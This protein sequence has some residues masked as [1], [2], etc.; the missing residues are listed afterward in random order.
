MKGNPYEANVSKFLFQLF[1]ATREK[2]GNVKG[3]FVFF[4]S[5]FWD[6]TFNK[7]KWNPEKI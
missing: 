6:L 4:K 2:W 7:P 3:S 5:L 1:V